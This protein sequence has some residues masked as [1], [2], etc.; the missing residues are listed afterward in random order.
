MANNEQAEGR[1]FNVLVEQ[2]AGPDRKEQESYLARVV[3]KVMI[4]QYGEGKVFPDSLDLPK[5]EDFAKKDVQAAWVM[6]DAIY[7]CVSKSL[8]GDSC[9]MLDIRSEVIKYMLSELERRQEIQREA[10]I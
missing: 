10:G 8:L 4:K 5:I 7:S 3:M 6:L 2:C 1:D 9:H